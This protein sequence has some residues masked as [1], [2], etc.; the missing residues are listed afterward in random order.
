MSR[1]D[2]VP[3]IGILSQADERHAEPLSIRGTVDPECRPITLRAVYGRCDHI[4][5]P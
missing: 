3:K 1:P 5:T 2:G 4:L